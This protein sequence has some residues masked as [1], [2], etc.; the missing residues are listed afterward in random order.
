MASASFDDGSPLTAA[1]EFW[2][3][4]PTLTLVTICLLVWFN[5]GKHRLRTWRMKRGVEAHPT[6]VAEKKELT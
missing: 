1:Q 3:L 5:W 6:I 4:A 2:W